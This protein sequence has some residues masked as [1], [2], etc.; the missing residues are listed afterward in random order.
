MGVV[1]HVSFR[2]EDRA[3]MESQSPS[4]HDRNRLAWLTLK[5]IPELGN[6]SLLHLVKHFGSPEDVLKAGAEQLASVPKLREQVRLSVLVRKT[7]RSPEVEWEKLQGKGIRLLCLGD[8][9]YP[10][11][12]AE[13][14]DPPAVLFLQGTVEPRDLVSIAVVGSRVASP[15]GLAFTE[16][17]CSE[18]A[19]HGVTIV[20]GFAVGIDSAAHRGAL[21]AKGRTLAVL[22]CGLD[23]DYP[24]GNSKLRGAIAERGALLSEFPLG[25]PPAPG[26]FPMRN[27]IISGLALGVVI[28]EAAQRSGSLITA[29]LALEQGR[30]VFAVPGMP[31][32]HRS[33]G[34]HMLL[35]QG[36]KLVE[37]AEDVLEEIRPIV[38]PSGDFGWMRQ[39]M[40]PR[41]ELAG[42]EAEVAVLL[43]QNPQHID[44]LCRSL[45]WPASRVMA[46]LLSLELKGV[47]RQLPGKHFVAVDSI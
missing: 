21:R 36:A 14:P 32:H 45:R 35:K 26:H 37:R 40:P 44:D 34:P 18:L 17:L 28:V 7:V 27:R 12:L 39:S 8:P 6:R 13:I 33:V 2:L 1:A 19:V 15:I 43:D 25:T 10:A 30:E 24:S 46:V 41:A 38:R 9:D 11:N 5:M 16:K 42:E 47:A 22:G 4:N 20:S 31:T 23:V 3:G 29:R